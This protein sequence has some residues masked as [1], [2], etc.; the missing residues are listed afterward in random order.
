MKENTVAPT[1]RPAK[2]RE[3]PAIPGLGEPLGDQSQS[4]LD[5]G[6]VRVSDVIV[7]ALV[8]AGV[9]VVFG[10]PGGT[11]GPIYDALLNQEQI[12]Q[13]T[14]SHEAGAMFAAAGY[15]QTAG[16]L[17]VVVVT[18][19]PGI[20]NAMNGLGSAFADHA[21]VLVLVGEVARKRYGCG[22]LQDGSAQGLNI[23]GLTSHV[24]KKSIELCTASSTKAQI[25]D[26]ISTAM[27]GRRGP[28]LVS[29]PVDLLSEKTIVSHVPVHREERYTIPKASLQATGNALLSP[30]KH[31]IFAGSGSR[32]GNGPL[33]LRNLAEKLSIPVMTTP[34]AKG[35]FPESHPLSLGIFGVAGHPSS[36]DFL[37]G[38]VDTVLAIG[39]SL[40]ETATDGW[41]ELLRPR[42]RL[43]QVDIDPN[44]IAKSY[45]VSLGIVAPAENFLVELF[46]FVPSTESPETYG[47]YHSS[48]LDSVPSIP[49]TIAAPRLFWELQQRLPTDTIFSTDSGANYC[50]AAH[51]LKLDYPD[52][53]VSMLGLASM[54]TAIGSAL[55]AQIAHP[56][57]TSVAV[58]GD[59]GFAM[60]ANE[61]STA[62]SLGLPIIIVVLN[63][64]C[65]T[66]VEMGQKAIFGRTH[67]FK[68]GPT[69]VVKLAKACGAD[70]MRI[71][72]PEQILEYSFDHSTQR[73]LVIDVR[74]HPAEPIPLG[75][76]FDTLGQ[77]DQ[78]A[79]QRN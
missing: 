22:A 48:P 19:G 79:S 62:A 45:D 53:F 29:L 41:S 55:G 54:G 47:M 59:G 20:L 7:Q 44:K 65:F 5:D 58:I 61:I 66:M 52:S 76:R 21:P 30:G 51:Y 17:G 32:V 74:I 60:C 26:A 38:G 78:P 9:E 13:V 50:W 71:D 57:R 36:S 35:V 12:K 25:N 34:K 28:T 69:D 3:L 16:K 31:V 18:S 72:G 4:A 49:G 10:I 56:S 6:R 33:T 43:I 2:E 1:Q 40:N 77:N 27:S 15:A 11:V 37:E 39:T 14:T 67:E 68:T 23:V 75:K 8:E 73:P 64:E 46:D 42:K 24:T 63:D 70:A